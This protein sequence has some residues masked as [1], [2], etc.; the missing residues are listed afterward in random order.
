M[1][2]QALSME[3]RALHHSLKGSRRSGPAIVISHQCFQLVVDVADE[4][5]FERAKIDLTEL[6]HSRCIQVVREG[7][8]EMLQCRVLVF[9]LFG[10]AKGPAQRRLK[11]GGKPGR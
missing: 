9:S 4:L 2:A 5:L 6:H 8:Q 3:S 7:K 11:L 10:V 1:T